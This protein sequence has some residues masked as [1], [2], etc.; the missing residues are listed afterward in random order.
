MQKKYTKNL[1]IKIKEA[2]FRADKKKKGKSIQKIQKRKITVEK[3][4]EASGDARGRVDLIV[5]FLRR[6]K[7][8]QEASSLDLDGEDLLFSEGPQE[9]EEEPSSA[10]EPEA[11]WKLISFE[12]EE[13]ATKSVT[14]YSRE[15]LKYRDTLAKDMSPQEYL[16]FSECAKTSF[17][18]PQK[19]QKFA[20]WSSINDYPLKYDNETLDII[21]QLAYEHLESGIRD[22]LK[23][24]T[25]KRPIEASTLEKFLEEIQK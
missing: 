22:L 10:K 15:R 24:D 21:G 6:N 4:K 20:Q 2:V 25:T 8:V 7:K 3:I 11:I 9:E 1:L 18:R 13:M 16:F 14:D 12:E 23:K 19:R 17:T 5:S